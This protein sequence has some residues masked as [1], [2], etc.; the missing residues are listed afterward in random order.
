[1]LTDIQKLEALLREWDV[2]WSYTAHEGEH[3]IS[4][5]YDDN[6]HANHG[7]KITGYPG[8]YTTY[9]FDADGKFMK[10]GAWE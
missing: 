1:M 7:E 8:F 9:Y 4:V 6:P 3:C 2:P 10:M 5:G